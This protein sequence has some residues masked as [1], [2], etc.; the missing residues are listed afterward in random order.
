V[1]AVSNY[2]YSSFDGGHSLAAATQWI[3][4]LLLGQ[5]GTAI[6]VLAVAIA[7]LNML[8][9]RLSVREGGRILLGCFIL[10]GAPAI[11]RGLMSAV[12]SSSTVI[13]IAPSQPP[14]SAPHMSTTPLPPANVNPFDPYTGAQAP[15]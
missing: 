7:G 4:G 13:S 15:N 14:A 2:T 1:S 6:A 8:W 10:F 9:G 3:Q 11:A 12:E 5:V